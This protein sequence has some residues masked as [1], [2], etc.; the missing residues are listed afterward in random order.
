[1]EGLQ[2]NYDLGLF[3]NINGTFQKKIDGF[4]LID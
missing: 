3:S 4:D 2:K 1:M